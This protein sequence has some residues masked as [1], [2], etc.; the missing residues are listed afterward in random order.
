MRCLD[1]ISLKQRYKDRITNIIAE[2]NTSIQAGEIEM[3]DVIR[4]A[5]PLILLMESA[6][7]QLKIIV[8][9]YQFESKEEEI[10]F[11]KFT[12][13][14]LFSKLIYYRKLYYLELKRPIGCYNK[15]RSFL[16]KEQYRINYF[17]EKN[18][19][20]IQYYRSGKTV[21]DEYY[22]LRGRGEFELNLECFYFERDPKFSTNFD[23]KVAK[24][25]AGD[26][27]VAYINSEYARLIQEENN[28]ESINGIRSNE[29]WTD[30]K[31]SL[32]EIIYGIDTL[33]SVNNGNIEIK[34]LAAMFGKMFN[35]DM[36]D[37]YR[38]YL[39]IRE[40]K[41]DRTVYLRKMIDALNKRMD[42]ADSRN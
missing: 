33:A 17:F 15:I 25:L 24:L 36:G 6:F 21:L 4:D 35:I 20:F 27:M 14:I 42:D 9:D 30:K 8:S 16:E 41:G 12:K 13:P 28:T 32:G 29:K 22:F 26:M 37:I 11:F 34:V 7:E 40:R 10:H 18:A 19:D 38:I 3:S 2:L 5:P 31:N 1:I 39:E 23:F